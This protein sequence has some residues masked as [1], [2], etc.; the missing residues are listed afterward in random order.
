M[1]KYRKIFKLFF[2]NLLSYILNEVK[3]KFS[4]TILVNFNL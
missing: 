2:D 1:F 3:L 4:K